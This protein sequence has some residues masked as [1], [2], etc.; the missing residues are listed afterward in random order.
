[1]FTIWLISPCPSTR[2]PARRYEI[3]IFCRPS[4]GYHCYLL[5]LSD[6]W[7]GVKKIDSFKEVHFFSFNLCPLWVCVISLLVKH[8]C[9]LVK[10]GTV[11]L[12][13]M[14]KPVPR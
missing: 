11:N 7:S 10:I 2:L 4:L 5:N 14:L 12:Q 6:L 13:K 8:T 9:T 3:Y 1:M